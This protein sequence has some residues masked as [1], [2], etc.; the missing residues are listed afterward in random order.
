L[1][2]GIFREE[3]R[4]ARQHEMTRKRAVDIDAQQPLGLGVAEG[5]LGIL[6]IGDERETAPVIGLSVE[7][8]TDV[9]RRPLQ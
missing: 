8:W 4:Q 7:R 9:T 2:F 6:Q 3:I 5:R 1:N